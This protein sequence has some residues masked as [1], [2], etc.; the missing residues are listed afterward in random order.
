MLKESRDT[1]V[2]LSP[3]NSEPMVKEIVQSFRKPY[4]CPT[5]DYARYE[6]RVDGI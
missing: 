4:L 2:E 3:G 6:F 5:S 1:E